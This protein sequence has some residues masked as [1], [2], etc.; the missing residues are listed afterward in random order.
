M[1]VHNTI[2]KLNKHL[3][4]NLRH[5]CNFANGTPN[6]SDFV[7]SRMNP[8][9]R[10]ANVKPYESQ[11]VAPGLDK[12]FNGEGG[13]G[14]N[15]GMEARDKWLPKNVDELRVGNNPKVTFDLNGHQGPANS[16]I[17]ESGNITTQGKVERVQSR[18]LL[19]SW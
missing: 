2:E 13:V 3:Y 7:Q 11:L 19:Y 15:S 10:Q 12:G 4:L 14:F 9:L 16:L 6:T 8:S 18:Y 5:R 1:G 17:K